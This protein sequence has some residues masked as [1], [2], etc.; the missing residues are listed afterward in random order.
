MKLLSKFFY[1]LCA[2]YTVTAMLMLLFNL[3]LAG[4]FEGTVIRPAAFLLIFPFALCLSL[5]CLVY[6][7]KTLPAAFRLGVHF[8][9][10]TGAAYLLLY[11]P[12]NASASGAGRLIMLCLFAL[13]YWLCM[14]IYLGIASACR[15]GEKPSEEYH[16]VFKK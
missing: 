10:C 11:L 7:A 4:G 5:A 2:A 16:S 3:A 8:V 12:T 9:I 13:L 6:E 14:G 15:K 1:V